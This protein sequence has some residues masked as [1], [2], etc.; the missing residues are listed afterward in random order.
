MSRATI[1]NSVEKNVIM[2]GSVCT[3]KRNSAQFKDV[4]ANTML[5][6][7]VGYITNNGIIG[8]HSAKLRRENIGLALKGK[9]RKKKSGFVGI[10]LPLGRTGVRNTRHQAKP[11]K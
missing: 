8:R 3:P 1:A 5:E 4:Q 2:P 7:C 9:S 10:T 11:V 6:E